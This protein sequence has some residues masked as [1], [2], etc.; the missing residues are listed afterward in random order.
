MP[1]KHANRARQTATWATVM[2]ALLLAGT[3]ICAYGQIVETYTTNVNEAIPDGNASGL[4]SV[5]SISSSIT[6]LASVKVTLNVAGQFNGDLY[7]YLRHVGSDGT[8]FCILLNRVGRSA[9]NSSGY[10]DSGMDVLFDDTSTNDIHTYQTVT[11]PASGNPLTGTWQPDGRAV[12]PDQVLDTSPRTT[13]L[14]SFTGTDASGQW[15]LY[16]ADLATGGTNMLAGWGLELNGIGPPVSLGGTVAYYTNYPASGLSSVRVGSVTMNVTGDTNVSVLTASDG[17]FGLSNITAG[18]TYCVTPSKSD[19]GSAANGVNG[20]DLVLVQRHILALAPLDSPYKLIA[21]DVNGSGDVNGTDLVLIQRLILAYTNSF[22]AGL[23][24]FVPADYVFPD[25]QNPWD[26]PSSVWTT[27]LVTDAIS[28]NFVAIKLGDVNDSWTPPG[29]GQPLALKRADTQA[30]GP[31][32]VFRLGGQSAMTGQ[33]V[34]VP[35]SV[36]QFRGVDN[37]QFTL[38]W[39]PRVL[40]YVG[41]EGYGLRG[42]SADSFGT[43]Q[44]EEGRLAFLWYDPEAV[45]VTVP[46]GTKIF[47]V[48]FEVIGRAGSGTAVTLGDTPTLREVGVDFKEAA[49]AEQSGEVSVVEPVVLRI[50]PVVSPG[51]AFQMSLPTESG[52][53][54]MLEYT[55]SLSRPGW[56]PLQAVEG[57]GTVKVLTDPAAPSRQ[58]FYRVRVQ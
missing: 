23:W 4:S 26:A 17:A 9:T 40:R 5:L 7:C 31:G 46:D 35:V 25:P 58:R 29:G 41:T 33:R 52:R 28:Q 22:P 30:V 39:D 54:Y 6:N 55:D 2:L 27:N 42:M 48:D 10:A 47:A 19:D 50:G 18:G 44:T 32:V 14:S 13:S 57:D 24:R 51:R 12:D 21:A 11:I 8:N 38:E 56:M 15:T 49:F 1:N 43:T 45:G 34:A 36:S 16:V 53:Q 3:G 37:A 20:T